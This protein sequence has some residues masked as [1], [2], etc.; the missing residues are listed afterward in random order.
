[1][2]ADELPTSPTTDE[3][4]EVELD[5][6]MTAVATTPSDIAFEFMPHTK[7]VRLPLD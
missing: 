3:V 7:Q 6:V 5:N 1:M 2:F 4:L